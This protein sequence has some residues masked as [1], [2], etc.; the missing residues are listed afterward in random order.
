MTL[1]PAEAE[2]LARCD[3]EAAILN[4]RQFLKPLRAHPAAYTVTDRRYL[5]AIARK[6][7][8]GAPTPA[9]GDRRHD[10]ET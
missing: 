7:G 6:Q 4:E 10:L 5:A 8:L 9:G 2:L 1:S 3:L